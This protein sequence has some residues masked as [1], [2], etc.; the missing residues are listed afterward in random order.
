MAFPQFTPL[1][2]SGGGTQ[3]TPIG[4][5][6]EEDEEKGGVLASIIQSVARDITGATKVG[7]AAAFSPFAALG[8]E[9]PV[10]FD[11]LGMRDWTGAASI[12]SMFVGGFAAAGARSMLAGQGLKALGRG[13]GAEG[14]KAAAQAWAARAGV[15][16]NAAL[17]AGAEA[18]AGAFFGAVR[19]LEQAES[20][21]EAVLGDAALFGGMGG[22]FSI[23]GSGMRA[24]VGVKV[25]QLKGT[26]KAALLQKTAER[27]EVTQRLTEYAGIALR[28]PENGVTRKITRLADGSVKMTDSEGLTQTF[29]DF[30]SALADSFRFGYEERLGVART[31]LNAA[32]LE[33]ALPDDIAEALGA[34]DGDLSKVIDSSQFANYKAVREAVSKAQEESALWDWLGGETIL[35][36]VDGSDAIGASPGFKNFRRDVLE[37]LPKDVSRALA[38]VEDPNEFLRQAAL[39]GA[40]DVE[41]LLT[42][43]EMRSFVDELFL[44]DVVPEGSSF[45]ARDPYDATFLAKF[46]T[47][48]TLAKIHPEIRPFTELTAAASERYTLG[49]RDA[50]QFMFELEN[51]VSRKAASKAAQIIDASAAAGGVR[52]SRLRAL[53]LAEETGDSQVIDFVGRVTERLNATRLRFI[54]AGRLGGSEADEN[55]VREA[56]RIIGEAA[57]EAGDSSVAEA[58][59]LERAPAG[60]KEVVEEL[61][62][63]AGR[64]GYFPIVHSGQI[65]VDINGEASPAF[66][67]SFNEARK[68]LV[69]EGGERGGFI[70]NAFSSDA[71]VSK[72]VSPAEF[73][74]LV[75]TIREID[76]VEISSKEA[77][78]LLKNSGTLPSR[79]PRK[80][81]QH[82]Q[83]R[84]LG[85]RDFAQDPMRG[86]DLYLMNAERTLAFNT[87]ARESNAIIENLPSAKSGLR[88][89]AE[90]Q[91][92]LVLGKPTKAERVVADLFKNIAPEVSQAALR[93]YS[94]LLRWGQGITKL[95]GLWSGAVNATQFAVNTV[96]I[97]GPK[98]AAEGLA[99]FFNPSTKAKIEQLVAKHKIDLGLHVSLTKEGQVIGAEG[100][101]TEIK[102]AISRLKLGEGKASAQALGKAAEN[103]WMFT[104]N[105]AERM[106]RLGTF[107]G[108]YKRGLAENMGEEGAVAF[109]KDMVLKTQFDYSIANL[110]QALQGPVG[111]VLGQFKTFFINEVELI[112]SLDNKTRLKMMA[113]FQALGGAGAILALPGADVADAASRYFFDVKASEAIKLEG[114]REDSGVIGRFAAFGAPG[115]FNADLTNYIGPGGF[116][117][118][119]MGLM[120]PTVSDLGAWKDFFAQGLRDVKSTGYLQPPTINAWMQRVMPAQI[121][122]FTRGAAIYETGEV[123]NPYSGKLIYRPDDRLKA[124]LATGIGIPTVQMSMERIQDD[125]ITRETESHRA[126]R[127]SYRRQIAL[128]AL[129]GEAGEVQRLTRQA[130]EAG[131]VFTPRDVQSAV[132]AFSL[133]GGERRERRTPTA[134]RSEFEEFFN[135][136]P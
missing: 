115:L 36:L 75:K 15:V 1:G 67:D 50:K 8:A 108:A 81:S 98:W 92:D 16:K 13:A 59:A 10:E 52:A 116:S 66:F 129:Q 119:T 106:N 42:G 2:A 20:R 104:F 5:G 49:A 127:E 73:G 39:Q 112:A 61:L 48:K 109:A 102:A 72:T 117:Q 135:L 134:L 85:L 14:A 27:R 41:N 70:S 118:L 54:G 120:G 107:W 58:L 21:L 79:G 56:R 90:T 23:L 29:S 34:V 99:A 94:G 103:M 84:R 40:V 91:R 97:L 55:L 6:N 71:L 93:K 114:G 60:V 130:G 122:R 74:K 76:G 86:L 80:Y 124:G 3:F 47:P 45:M 123:R 131:Y 105:G 87:F 33:D 77:A 43:K 12:A 46:A 126:S 95:G 32:T 96:P 111:S 24:T 83:P 17:L 18:S 133:T 64:A 63:D 57:E 78:E 101:S 65:R 68:F 31:R 121:R 25:A 7:V 53:E 89:W 26:T 9:V 51:T 35:P 110:P 62:D 44:N 19:P 38:K 11:D 113:M 136:S 132:K 82:L 128:A 69:E 37:I 88:E 28:N 100:A 22:A 4:F 125:I 30:N